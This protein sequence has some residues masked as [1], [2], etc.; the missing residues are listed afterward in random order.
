MPINFSPKVGEILEC[1]YGNYPVDKEGKLITNFYDGHIPPEIV[2]NR[3]VVVMNGKIDGNACIVVPLSSKCDQNKFQRGMH[4]EISQNVIEDMK[5]FE[6]ITRW[7][8]ADLVQQVS[9]QRLRR[10]K[11]VNRSYLNQILPRE[12]VTKIQLAIVKSINA[13]QLLSKSV[14]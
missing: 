9:R 8:K 6:Q 5:Y 7:A 11:A 12:I 2:K 1:D 13:S 10:P 3:L 4:V 14:T